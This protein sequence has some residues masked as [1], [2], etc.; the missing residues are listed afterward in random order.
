[1]RPARRVLVID[2]EASFCRFM[3]RMITS[4]GYEVTTTC[5][6]KCAYL[7]EL[8]EPDVV[9]IDMVM[10]EMDGIQVLEVLADYKVKAAIVLMSGADTS[11][12]K[13]EAF[14]KRADLRLIGVLHKPFRLA[15]V[16]NIFA[17]D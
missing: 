4:L 5:Q 15:D 8:K 2:D 1:M 17:A 12:S 6:A 11:L 9:F 10:P 16:Q 7:D 13:A 14:A 3:A